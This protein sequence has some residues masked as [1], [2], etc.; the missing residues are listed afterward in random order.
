MSDQTPEISHRGRTPPSAQDG[1]TIDVRERARVRPGPRARRGPRAH[2]PARLPPRRDRP[3]RPRPR[4]LRLGQPLEGDDRPAGRRGL[5]RRVGR[6][7]HPRPG[8]PPAAPWGWV[9]DG[10]PHR[11]PHRDAHPRRPQLPRARR[12]GRLR[13]RPAARHRPRARPCSTSTACAS[14]TS[15]RPTSTTTTS[16]AASPSRSA[17]VPSTSSTARTTCPSTAPPLADGQVVEVGGRMRVTALATPGHTFTHLSYALTD[18]AGDGL[19]RS[20]GVFSGG[21]LLYGATGRPDLL[22]PE[23]THDLVR[24]QHASAHRLAEL[25]PD[26]AGGL[27]D[28]RL[29]LLLL[30]HPVRRHARRPSAGRSRPT[31]S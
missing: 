2:G 28:P 23:H 18:R 29:R 1:V 8:S 17:P 9:C 31:R 25:L 30:R 27:P 19:D 12:R 4:H 14:P 11:R 10:R 13:G 5:R 22:G 20:V 16:P 3:L 21:S 7:R 6:R 26:D 15:S 24:H